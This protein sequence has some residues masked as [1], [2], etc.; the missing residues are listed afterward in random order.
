MAN[1]NHI[2][3]TVIIDWDLRLK[4]TKSCIFAEWLAIIQLY[5]ELSIF[6]F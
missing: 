2:S 4:I 5:T 1:N 3:S 6:R